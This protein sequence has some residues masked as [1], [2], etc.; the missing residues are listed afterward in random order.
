[1]INISTTPGSS[2]ILNTTQVIS[3]GAFLNITSGS[4]F[5]INGGILDNPSAL[6]DSTVLTKL[7]LIDTTITSPDDTLTILE[8]RYDDIKRVEGIVMKEYYNTPYEDSNVIKYFY[9]GNDTFPFKEIE[10]EFYSHYLFYNEIN[11]VIK[12]SVTTSN[13]Q[14][15]MPEHVN[16]FSYSGTTIFRQT[17]FYNF[18]QISLDTIFQTF[19]TGNVVAQNA[20]SSNYGY[21]FQLDDHPNPMYQVTNRINA[22][23][24]VFSG[25]STFVMSQQKNNYTQI[26]N[27]E[28][29]D[30]HNKYIYDYV[31]K[32]NGYPAYFRSYNKSTGLPVYAGTGIYTYTRL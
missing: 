11:K 18:N 7:I 5:V 1:M 26:F 15:E 24:P 16:N 2:C 9:K 13:G 27:L 17:I 21:T 10:N 3:P 8:Y 12:D 23:F 14:F 25:D 31:Y 29:E 32:Q 19:S 4:N 6:K 28:S 20:A 22:E 30:S